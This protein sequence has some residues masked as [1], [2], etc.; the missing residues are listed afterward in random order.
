M[1]LAAIPETAPAREVLRRVAS[2]VGAAAEALALVEAQ[3]AALMAVV[4]PGDGA[5]EKLQALDRLT[6][7]MRAVEVFLCAAAMDA[8]GELALAPALDAVLLEGV[9]AR[10]AGQG[11]AAPVP[12]D[13]ELW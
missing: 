11:E 4:S 10:L 9:R 6:Q 13:V 8:E 2:E 12:S 1:K 7:Q 5:V 3:V